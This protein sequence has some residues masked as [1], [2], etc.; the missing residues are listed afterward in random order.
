[1]K[2]GVEWDFLEVVMLRLG[3]CDKWVRWIMRCVTSVDP[4][5]MILGRNV[6]SFLLDKGIRHYLLSYLCL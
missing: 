2:K 1:M 5:L 4:N 3:F 6:D